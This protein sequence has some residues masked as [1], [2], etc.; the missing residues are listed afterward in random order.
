MSIR[1]L[2][3]LLAVVVLATDAFA[4]DS[5]SKTNQAAKIAKRFE[6]KQT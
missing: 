2:V 5:N 3:M 4:Q 6:K 1:M